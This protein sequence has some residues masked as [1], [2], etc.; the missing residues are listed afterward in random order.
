MQTL[1]TQGNG[2][3][4]ETI[5]TIKKEG[6]QEGTG[7]TK[8]ELTQENKNTKIKQNNEIKPQTMTVCLWQAVSVS[9]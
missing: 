3:Q 1:N 4:V 9:S 8:A 7:N 2:E 5:R 6:K